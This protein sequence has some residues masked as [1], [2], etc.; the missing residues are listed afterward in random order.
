M[1]DQHRG[2]SGC[3]AEAQEP[4]DMELKLPARS[5]EKLAESEVQGMIQPPAFFH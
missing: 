2:E 5:L 4:S 1:C 3:D